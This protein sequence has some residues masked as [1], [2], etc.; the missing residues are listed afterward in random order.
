MALGE[1]APS[2]TNPTEHENMYRDALKTAEEM[3]GPELKKMQDTVDGLV[4]AADHLL[5][6]MQG[7]AVHLQEQDMKSALLMGALKDVQRVLQQNVS[8]IKRLQTTVET[9]VTPNT[10][11]KTK[12]SEGGGSY[13]QSTMGKG[14]NRAKKGSVDDDED[15]FAV[16]LDISDDED[17]KYLRTR[18]PKPYSNPNPKQESVNTNKVQSFAQTERERV[19]GKS[20]CSKFSVKPGYSEYR[21]G[22]NSKVTEDDGVEVIPKPRKLSFT[23]S[24]SSQTEHVSNRENQEI[25]VSLRRE[26]GMMSSRYLTTPQDTK[27]VVETAMRSCAWTRVIPYL[28][29]VIFKVGNES[30][31][32]DDFQTLCP[33][34]IPYDKWDVTKGLSIEEMIDRYLLEWLPPFHDLK[35]AEVL[36]KMLSTEWFPPKFSA[37][38]KELDGWEISDAFSPSKSVGIKDYVVIT[39]S[40]LWIM[41]WMYMGSAF[42]PNT[43]REASK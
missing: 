34:R 6:I 25:K 36:A 38:K 13:V 24:P 20:S 35:Y 27:L 9:I 37:G 2:S 18:K 29:E 39:K 1:E 16:L 19:Y 5:E 7:M 14:R 30:A 23:P 22:P 15:K 33:D 12:P 11:P 8:E 21:R 26:K 31:T 3:D 10:A 43:L 17:V 32:L 41:D 28:S 40:I 42:Q 4:C